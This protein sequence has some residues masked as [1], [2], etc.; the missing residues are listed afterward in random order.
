MSYPHPTKITYDHLAFS[1]DSGHEDGR[2]NSLGLI[3]FPFKHEESLCNELQ[4]IFSSSGITDEFKWQNVRSAKYKFASEK[5]H[6]FV[7]KHLDKIRIDVLIWDT[8]DSRHKDVPGRDDNANTGRMYYQ[9]IQNV[10]NKRWGNNASWFWKPDKQSVMDW[11][12]LG[13]CLVGKKH[14]LAV[15]LF[16]VNETDFIKLKLKMIKVVESHKEIFVQVADYFAGLGAYSYGHFDKYKEWEESQSGQV[17]L[18]EDKKVLKNWSNS[19][20][21]RFPL[22]NCF[23]NECKSRTLTVALSSTKGLKTHDPPKPINFWL[24]RPQHAL[25]KAP[26]YSDGN[27]NFI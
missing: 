8:E 14:N 26:R 13:K 17:S 19:E 23:N 25:D 16:G 3:T 24:Y 7:F 12:T 11:Q 2:Y 6:A 20:K 21:T 18:F 4:T 27:Q 10:L 22:I 9:L 1:D 5:L 15:D